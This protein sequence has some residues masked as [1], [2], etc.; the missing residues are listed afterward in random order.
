MFH[1]QEGPPTTPDAFLLDYIGR[2]CGECSIEI[3]IQRITQ[4]YTRNIK[5][6]PWIYNFKV[7][8]RKR[9]TKVNIHKDTRNI[10]TRVFRILAP[11]TIL[12]ILA[13][14]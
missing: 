7:N 12:V 1:F 3:H 6:S 14:F 5:K 10:Y 9:N 4:E 13:K 8:N 11:E 2:K